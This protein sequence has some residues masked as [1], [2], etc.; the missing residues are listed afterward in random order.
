MIAFECVCVV[1]IIVSWNEWAFIVSKEMS[2]KSHIFRSMILIEI[3]EKMERGKRVERAV[4]CV[5]VRLSSDSCVS[6]D[7]NTQ[8]H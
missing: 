6:I 4:G 1:H 3:V 5:C 8:W 2:W 7:V